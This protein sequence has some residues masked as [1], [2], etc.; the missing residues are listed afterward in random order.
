RAV[1]NKPPH[2]IEKA[3]QR[4]EAVVGVPPATLIP[5]RQ[6]HPV[7]HSDHFEDVL[8]TAE[9]IVRRHRDPIWLVRVRRHVHPVGIR[10][11]EHLLDEVDEMPHRL[12]TLQQ[13][14]KDLLSALPRA[15]FVSHRSGRR[16]PYSNYAPARPSCRG[17]SSAP[18]D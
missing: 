13:V 8:S 11:R 17:K 2:T 5:K 9:L 14:M 10:R 18:P 16:Y 6:L 4:R 1:I 7:L 15:P 3:L 12:V